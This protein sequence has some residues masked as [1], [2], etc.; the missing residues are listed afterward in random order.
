MFYEI[1]KMCNLIAISQFQVRY[2]FWKIIYIWPYNFESSKFTLDYSLLNFSRLGY[3]WT[4]RQ[5]C[6]KKITVIQIFYVYTAPSLTA[7]LREHIE[8]P[9]DERTQNS[10]TFQEHIEA[11]IEQQAGRML[12]PGKFWSDK[13]SICK[14]Q[15]SS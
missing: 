10:T 13:S 8:K 15:L 3:K 9:N 14:S 1:I 5:R 2:K 4:I 12:T 6:Y 11:C 7:V